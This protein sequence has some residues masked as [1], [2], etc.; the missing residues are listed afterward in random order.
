M[1]KIV[2]ED[3]N[4]GNG[5]YKVNLAY[6]N[7]EQVEEIETLVSKWNPSDEDIKSCIAM[8]LTD[9]NEQRF[10]AYG[11]TFEECLTWLEK[12]IPKNKTA[13]DKA[14]EDEVNAWI[15]KQNPIKFNDEEDERI[16]KAQLDYW[17]SVGGK[18]WYGVPVQEAIAWLEKKLF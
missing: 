17:C 9:A 5:Y 3:F 12:Q 18:E 13:L 2:L 11:T 8:C 7:K 10:K 15:E 6:L 4:E 1:S 16:R 14:I